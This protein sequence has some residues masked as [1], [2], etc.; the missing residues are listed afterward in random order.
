MTEPS[1]A[2]VES[3]LTRWEQGFERVVT[4]APYVTLAIGLTLG[5]L[6]TPESGRRLLMV[7]LA[8]AAALWTFLVFTRS[9]AWQAKVVRLRLYF[10]GFLVLGAALMLVSGAF[11]VYLI[12]GFIHAFALKPV[13]LAFVGVGLTSVLINRGIVASNPTS[14]DWWTYGI[15]VAI[16][17]TVVGFG[18]IGGEKIAAL[19]EQRA[20]SLRELETAL[21]E[22]EDLH[23]Q[24][25]AQAREA[26]VVDERQ[27]MARE[28][29][30]TIAQGLIGVITQLEAARNEE[31]EV[32]QRIDHATKLARESLAEARRSVQALVP[33]QLEGRSLPDALG[34][35]AERWALLNDIPTVVTTTGAVVTLRPELEVALL[36]VVQEALS[37]IAKHA[38][39]S[40]VGVTLSYLGDVVNIDVRDDGVGITS[41]G[42]GR[43]FGLTSMRQRVAALSGRLEI[44]SGLDEGTAISVSL[45][46]G[47][48]NA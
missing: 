11:F 13:A 9:G 23:A 24:V 10:V 41:N 43:G 34:N 6:G 12:T 42:D 15:I 35:V 25:V 22:N 19:S 31:G 27:R 4:W 18:V 40:R 28:I 8:A 32:R 5:L 26:A 29:H 45:P 3:D 46:V 1:S 44:E 7:G 33:A 30:D 47:G 14:D 48:S 36:R 2:P 16:Q 21:K 20:R 38:K 17:S 37:N 39:A